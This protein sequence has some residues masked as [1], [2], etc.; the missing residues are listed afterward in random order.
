[1]GMITTIIANAASETATTVG[2]VGGLAGVIWLVVRNEMSNRNGHAYPKPNGDERT[3]E[4]LDKLEADISDIKAQLAA[5]G[6][7][8]DN[9]AEK[10][11]QLYDMLKEK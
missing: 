9:H 10:L 8:F 11:N 5:G 7:R 2:G 1:M 3:V 4:K 6:E